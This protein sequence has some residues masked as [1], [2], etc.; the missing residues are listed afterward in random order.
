MKNDFAKY[1]IALLIFNC[2]CLDVWLIAMAYAESRDTGQFYLNITMGTIW[3]Q[4][5]LCCAA[6]L[7]FSEHQALTKIGLIAIPLA[8]IVVY[9]LVDPTEQLTIMLPLILM[10]FA[11]TAVVCLAPATIVHWLYRKHGRQLGMKHMLV[12]T[13]V[14]AVASF[15]FS[16]LDFAGIMLLVF[17]LV[18]LPAIVACIMLSLPDQ[19]ILYSVTMVIFLVT[20]LL[21]DQFDLYHRY[22]GN[23]QDILVSQ[24]LCLWLAGQFLL[25]A[26]RD[27]PHELERAEMDVS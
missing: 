11:L 20:A 18:A 27:V 10:C 8:S 4:Y 16:Q 6:R 1:A 2:L 9:P 14:F 7:R 23:T 21:A 24:T 22:I 3:G 19:P 5:A 12:L 17:T 13:I 15:G 25:A 26:G